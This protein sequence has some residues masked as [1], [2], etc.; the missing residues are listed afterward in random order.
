MMA[1]RAETCSREKIDKTNVV[2]MLVRTLT[3][4]YHQ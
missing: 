1:R 2:T 3:I 4:C